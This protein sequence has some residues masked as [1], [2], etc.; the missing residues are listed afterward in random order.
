MENENEPEPREPLVSNESTGQIYASR[1]DVLALLG[2]LADRTREIE[3]RLER[4]LQH[5]RS[6]EPSGLPDKQADR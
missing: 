5:E 1:N 3:R 6:S 4:I 2:E